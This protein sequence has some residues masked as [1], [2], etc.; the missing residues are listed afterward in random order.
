MFFLVLRRCAVSYEESNHT[1]NILTFYRQ[2][3]PRDIEKELPRD[4]LAR[5]EKRFV[6]VE[7]PTKLLPMSGKSGDIKRI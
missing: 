2:V 3:L 1:Y 7:K 4:D 5:K 6:I